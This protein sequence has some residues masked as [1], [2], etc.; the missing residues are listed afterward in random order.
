MK[1]S[2]NILN[3][4]L[5]LSGIPTDQE[6]A[7]TSSK[8]NDHATQKV[9]PPQ[10]NSYFIERGEDLLSFKNSM[11]ENAVV[12]YY[13]DSFTSSSRKEPFSPDFSEYVPSDQDVSKNSSQHSSEHNIPLQEIPTATNISENNT[14]PEGTARKVKR[15]VPK[16]TNPGRNRGHN[17]KNWKRNL[18][19]RKKN[20]GE[21]YVNRSGILVPKKVMRSGCNNACTRKCKERL[22]E[23]TRHAIFK[24]FWGLGDHTRQADFVC[25]FVDRVP[26]KQITASVNGHS[27]RHWS[28]Q[29][30]L[31]EDGDRKR[32]CKKCFLI[33]CVLVICGYKLFTKKW[34]KK[35]LGL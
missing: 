18:S 8:A 13:P 31:Y 24:D 34:T 5:S 27:R 12:N 16:K 21:E 2:Q 19:K 1:R 33:L 3:L 22:M 29:Y 9:I 20:S 7:S 28:F 4:A 32:V 14:T 25:R 10:D 17:R 15:N 6:V 23:T 35:A 30:Y 26:R 11:R